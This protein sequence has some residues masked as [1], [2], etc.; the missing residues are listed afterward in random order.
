MKGEVLDLDPGFLRGG[1]STLRGKRVGLSVGLS[2]DPLRLLTDA[3][4]DRRLD[5]L[6]L[7][8]QIGGLRRDPLVG[9]LADP[10]LGF[11]ARKLGLGDAVLGLLGLGQR[12]L[13]GSVDAVGVG[14]L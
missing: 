11:G 3:V 13:D 7:F 6:E 8:A 12:L 14:R 2:P 1:G 5:V 10:P 4:V 9:L